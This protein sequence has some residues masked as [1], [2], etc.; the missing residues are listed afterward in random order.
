MA[1]R[2]DRSAPPIWLAATALA[3]LGW[4]FGS[5]LQPLWWFAWLAPLPVLC[6]APRVRTPW[7]AL[8]AFV[9]FALGGLNQWVYLH[10]AIR[11][12]MPI[13]MYAIG[14]P[15]IALT[16]CVVLYRRLLLRGHT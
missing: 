14:M 13:V 15:A 12:P 10:E 7:A 5:G 11:L 1:S 16:L 9:A 2:P 4:W 8:A 3:A 6:L